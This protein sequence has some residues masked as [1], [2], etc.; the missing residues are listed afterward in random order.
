MRPI[1]WALPVAVGCAVSPRRPGGPDLETRVLPCRKGGIVAVETR[2]PLAVPFPAAAGRLLAGEALVRAQS[3]T[4]EITQWDPEAALPARAGFEA[5]TAAEAG[6]SPQAQAVLEEIRRYG[7]PGAE[8]CQSPPAPD[9]RL[10]LSTFLT[11]HGPFHVLG[12]LRTMRTERAAVLVELHFLVSAEYEAGVN[13]YH[14]EEV[15]EG[16]LTLTVRLWAWISQVEGML[17]ALGARAMAGAEMR[18]EA[19]HVWHEVA[20]YLGAP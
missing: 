10:Y 3:G 6:V 4:Q 16:T 7:G 1:L 9:N 14:V 20:A 18:R 17:G 13:V 19:E 15:A 8:L 12:E 5:D 11:S 2:G